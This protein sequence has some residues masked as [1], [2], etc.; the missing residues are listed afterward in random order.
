MKKDKK[1]ETKKYILPLIVFA[2]VFVSAISFAIS[3]YR[4]ENKHETKSEVTSTAPT[5]TQL[6]TTTTQETPTKTAFTGEIP[7]LMYHYIRDY[8]DSNDQIGINLSVSPAKFSTQLDTIKSLGYTPINFFDIEKGNLPQKPIILTFDDGYLDFYTAAYPELK[9]HNM[10]AVSYVITGKIGGAYMTTDMIKTLS[11]NNIE[12]G[13]HTISHPDLSMMSVPNINEEL[14]T[15]KKFL[16]N[17]LGKPVISFC[18][19]A[20]KYSDAVVSSTHQAGYLYATTTNSGEA[21]FSTPLTL[22]RYRISPTT[23]ITTFLK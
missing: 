5:Q 3:K 20:G 19:P 15:S 18:Y 21:N 12:I 2:I 10:T 1:I 9:S 7:I 22:S 11:T 8:T 4:T 13:S 16:E 6:S 23:N 17:L 14:V